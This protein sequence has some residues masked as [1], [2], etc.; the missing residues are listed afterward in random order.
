MSSLDTK[1]PW[2]QELDI[3]DLEKPEADKQS[4]RE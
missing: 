4:P 2:T 1:L 3:Q